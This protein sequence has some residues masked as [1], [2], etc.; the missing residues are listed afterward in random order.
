MKELE[1]K[2]IFWI[3]YGISIALCILLVLLWYLLHGISV[4]RSI[5]IVVVQKSE[6][7]YVGIV[8]SNNRIDISPCDTIHVERDGVVLDF[9]IVSRKDDSGA[10]LMRRVNENVVN[11]EYFAGRILF[12]D[13]NLWN[14]VF[15][16]K[17]IINL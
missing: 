11:E 15:T 17:S 14:T 2:G 1:H 13:T 12:P 9:V 5:P 6:C 16:L 4:N 10:M 8:S 7:D 3:R